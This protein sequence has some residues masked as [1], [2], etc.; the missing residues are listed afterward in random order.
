MLVWLIACRLDLEDPPETQDVTGSGGCT[1]FADS[2][3]D[4][5]G[6]AEVLDC[7]GVEEGT[8]CD[9]TRSNVFPDAAEHCDG[10][11]EDCD[12]SIDDA[13]VDG[14]GFADADGDGHGD[15]DAPTT[16]CAVASSD[17]CD[18]ADPGAHPG[19]EE[20]CDGV[21]NDC[22][23]AADEG[24]ACEITLV[25]AQAIR[26]YGN[27]EGGYLGWP[28]DGGDLDGDNV[29]DVV[30]LSSRG[31]YAVS[32]AN[33]L[34][35]GSVDLDTDATLLTGDEV[36]AA[37]E[38][39]D[40][41]MLPDGDGDG[42]ADLLLGQP[43]GTG[44]AWLFH[45]MPETGGDLDAA[46]NARIHASDQGMVGHSVASA[47]DTDGDGAPELLVGAPY[48]PSEG[49][50]FGAAYLIA[51]DIA[52]DVDAS[53]VARSVLR[54]PRED[55][56]GDELEWNFAGSGV[57]GAGDVDGDGL[58]DVAIGGQ[59]MGNSCA[60]AVWVALSP[61]SADLD[62]AESDAEIR[63]PDFSPYAAFVGGRHHQIESLGDVDGDG[64][65]DLGLSTINGPDGGEAALFSATTRGIVEWTGGFAVIREVANTLS[66][67]GP[68]DVDGDGLGD[69]VIG[70]RG[71]D[72]FRGRAVLFQHGLAGEVSLEDADRVLTG[73]NDWTGNVI[74]NAGDVDGDGV[75]DLWIDAIFDSVAAQ[76][77]GAAALVLGGTW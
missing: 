8:D 15:P 34:A 77:G 13:P 65:P 51:G 50:G 68:G 33:A 66:L 44:G 62:L 2:D 6:D 7:A 58:D 55:A 12:G 47:G 64:L 18:D 20:Q 60:G 14:G 9:D 38:W 53:T 57:M 27:V 41:A 69:V 24:D 21:D 23:G 48:S 30:V 46:A 67:T 3:G 10:V 76:Y 43:Y 36:Y 16:A 25:D 39:I 72:D 31:V 35:A 37:G 40:S 56:D 22:N 75:P 28:T 71:W 42:H 52:G 19:A 45:E 63:G 54:G 5:F 70:D 29:P 1:T 17:D 32:M 49:N 74:A 73:S 61:L 26:I 11:D 4:G 59:G